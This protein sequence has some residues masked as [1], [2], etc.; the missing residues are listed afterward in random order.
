MCMIVKRSLIRLEFS[1][2]CFTSD[3]VLEFISQI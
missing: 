1:A 2:F 3:L